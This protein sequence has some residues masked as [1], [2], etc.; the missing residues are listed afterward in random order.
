[1]GLAQLS[2]GEK[3]FFESGG[4]D[5]GKLH[6]ENPTIAPKN[7][8]TGNNANVDP[9]NPQLNLEPAEETPE[10]KQ[11]REAKEQAEAAKVERE[12]KRKEAIE[13]LGL[14]PLEALQEARNEGKLTKR[15][16]EEL[17]AWKQQIEPLL[18]QLPKPQAKPQEPNPYDPN[19]Q[20]A[21]FKAFQEWIE[22]KQAVKETAEWRR[23]QE[24]LA[25]Q[26]ARI[27]QAAT[28]AGA[29]ETEFRKTQP[30]YDAAYQYAEQHRTKELEA[31]GMPPQMVQATLAQNR[32]E[33]VQLAIQ[34]GKNPAQIVWDLALGRGFN[35]EKGN[36]VDKGTEA[37]AK[38]RA[39][40][41]AA[42]GLNGGG[43]TPKGELSLEDINRMPTKTPAQR[44]AYSEAW[45]K[46]WATH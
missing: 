15:E 8:P 9:E 12:K 39:G 23:Q 37:A 40:Q 38:I 24:T 43:A 36:G 5:T 18:A 20:P 29:Q 11:A 28:W 4:T 6:E 41:K 30:A 19:T 26:N 33:I 10:A 21:E 22:T 2:D 7:G 3:Q 27:Q 34:T 32:M 46:Y 44:K 16:L 35:P 13:G 14:V 31:M 45:D 17:K 42:G 25:Q 1:M